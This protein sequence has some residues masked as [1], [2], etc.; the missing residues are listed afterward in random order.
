MAAHR[1][2]SFVESSERQSIEL[3]LMDRWILSRLARSMQTIDRAM[4]GMH[5]HVAVAALKT[6]FYQNFCDVYL[7]SG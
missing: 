1:K 2:W 6:F 7:V 4:D 3:S 5:F